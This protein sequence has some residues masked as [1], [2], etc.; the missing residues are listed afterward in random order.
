MSSFE[1][2]CKIADAVLYEGYVLYPYRASSMKNRYRWQF[3]VIAPPAWSEEDGEPCQMQTECLIEPAESPAV[4]IAIRFLQI[5]E[6]DS[7]QAGW[8]DGVERRIEIPATPLSEYLKTPK[9]VPFELPTE[10][11]AISGHVHVSATE[12]NG[13]VKLRVLLENE[14]PLPA[15]SDRTIAMRHSLVGTHTLFAVTGGAFISLTDPPAAARDAARS[16]ANLHTWPVLVGAADDR[17]T[18]LSS[19]IILP[20]Y[21]Q[22]APESAGDFYDAT[23]IDEMLTLRVMTLTD[24]EKREAC[25]TD[26]RARRIVE[27]SSSIPPEMFERLHGALRHLPPTNVE[28]FFNPPHEDPD[29]AAIE[30][31]GGLIAKG[32]RVRL[33]PKHRADSMDMFL[34]GRIAIVE[35][36]HRDVEDRAFVAV[37]MEGEAAA[38]LHGV[39]NRF[40]YFHPDEIESIEL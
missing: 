4:E 36:V 28:Q 9:I 35:A 37:R 8:D 16:C 20:D 1:A 27:R 3:G 25:A 31:P 11:T 24:E 7:E 5:E 30:T 19:P 32:A 12:A 40:Y 10:G 33:A 26:E 39:Y 23:E 34:A 18:L 2:A 38:D 17:Q 22:V 13:Y 14:T 21:P 15:G 6:R 29:H